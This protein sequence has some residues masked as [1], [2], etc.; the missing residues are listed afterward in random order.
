MLTILISI[1]I[2]I[3]FLA[4]VEK[5]YKMGKKE[6]HKYWDM[7]TEDYRN[8]INKLESEIYILKTKLEENHS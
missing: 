6:I 5:A 3:A 4:S 8:H 1:I 7:D 2:I